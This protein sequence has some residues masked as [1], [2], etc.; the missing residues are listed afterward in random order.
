MY[1]REKEKIALFIDGAN[2]HGTARALGFDIDYRK[3][4]EFFRQRG[5]LLRAIY[6]TA[7]SEDQEFSSIRP[8]IDWLEYNGFTTVTKPTKNFLDSSGRRKTKCS[9]DIELTVDAMQLARS[10]DHIVLFTGDGDFRVLVSTLQELGC[11]VSVVSTLETKPPMISDDLR[12][13]A[14]Q[15]IDLVDIE[16]SIARDSG[17]RGRSNTRRQNGAPDAPTDHPDVATLSDDDLL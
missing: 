3:L 8:L 5:R 2:F 11:R 4:L 7:L 17:E 1:F 6:Y 15:F 12:R 9:M 16:D 10:L 13:Q 14:D